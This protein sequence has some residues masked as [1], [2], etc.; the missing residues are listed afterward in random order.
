MKLMLILLSTLVLTSCGKKSS[1]SNDRP[2]SGFQPLTDAEISKACGNGS[3]N[4][5]I[6]GGSWTTDISD[7]SL[8]IPE[9]SFSLSFVTQSKMNIVYYCSV[10]VSEDEVHYLGSGNS[11]N[12]SMTERSLE[13]TNHSDI[14]V[15]DDEGREVCSA[16]NLNGSYNVG[17]KGQ[18]IY[19]ELENEK[20]YFKKANR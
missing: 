2:V 10:A 20:I 16:E 1:S 18:C 12:Y 7:E 6:I 15:S 11:A 9:D 3:F 19:L 8:K 13:I 4:Q 17:T 5:E 14:I